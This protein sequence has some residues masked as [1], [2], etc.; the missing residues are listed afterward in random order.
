MS[1][2]DFTQRCHSEHATWSGYA[3]TWDWHRNHRSTS[4]MR[5]DEQLPQARTRWYT[6]PKTGLRQMEVWVSAATEREACQVMAE[7]R[8]EY[9]PDLWPAPELPRQGVL[10]A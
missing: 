7:L 6:D 1:G 3:G 8:A 4:L 10:F 2:R 9:D 5:A